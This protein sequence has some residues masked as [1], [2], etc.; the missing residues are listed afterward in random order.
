MPTIISVIIPCRNEEA[1]IVKCL[2]SVL[3]FEIPAETEIEVLV[4]DGR[5]TDRTRD[6]VKSTTA[7]DRRV[8]LLDNPGKI[9]STAVN[10]GVRASVGEWIMRLDAHAEYP[11]NYLMLCHETAIR[12]KADNVGGIFIT[13]PGGTGY[14]ALLVQ[15]LTTHKFGVGDSGFRTGA[16]EDWADTV[17]YGFYRRD[18]FTKLGWLD[19]RLV[20]AQDYEFNRRIIV[21]GGR[22][23]RNP[24]IQIKY[25]NQPTIWR[26]LG[27]QIAKEAPYNA[28]LWY[29][30]PYAFAPRHA[31]T[32]VFSAGLLGGLILSPLTPWIAWPFGA[33]MAFYAL[34][35][36]LS[37]LQQAVRYRQPAHALLL[38]LCFFLYHFIHGLGVL[39][40]LVRLITH[41]APVQKANEPWPGAGRF[42]VTPV[43]QHNS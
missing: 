23:L 4:M 20:R 16:K 32:G 33:I 9:Q 35:A 41:T 1:Y 25:Y 40:G 22:I 19:E 29:I 34:L 5:S 37:G 17:P 10:L 36:V 26:F 6:L 13:Q 42:R 2:K 8:R 12:S 7:Q 27:K 43:A 18:V 3:S 30:A 21:S 14:G 28:Y 31:I 15:A 39:I 38:P 24:L 11:P